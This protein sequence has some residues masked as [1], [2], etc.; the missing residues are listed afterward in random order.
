MPAIAKVVKDVFTE[1]ERRKKIQHYTEES[2]IKLVKKVIR[3]KLDIEYKRRIYCDPRSPRSASIC[4]FMQDA[5]DTVKKIYESI[6]TKQLSARALPV[7]S[8][9]TPSVL[10]SGSRTGLSRRAVIMSMQ[11]NK[12]DS[13]NGRCRSEGRARGQQMVEAEDNVKNIRGKSCCCE[14]CGGMEY[15]RRV[16]RRI[17]IFPSLYRMELERKREERRYQEVE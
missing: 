7:V 17:N 9:R 16:Q 8:A 11:A 3:M 13:A 5:R 4:Q 12:S 6:T 2:V 10:D 14:A 15:Y 1:L